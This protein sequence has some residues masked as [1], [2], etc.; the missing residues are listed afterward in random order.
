ML[1]PLQEDHPKEE[2][3]EDVQIVSV[4]PALSLIDTPCQQPKPESAVEK[5]VHIY[6]YTYI[7]IG[8]H[9]AGDV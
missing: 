6:I 5:R 7:Q 4:S 2:D 3:G 9:A 1:S 8:I